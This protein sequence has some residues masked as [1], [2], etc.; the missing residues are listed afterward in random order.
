MWPLHHMSSSEVKS[1]IAEYAKLSAEFKS[2]DAVITSRWIKY[3]SLFT[4]LLVL[5]SMYAPCHSRL[6]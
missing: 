6:Y 1:H 4:V 3:Q 2:A 5:L